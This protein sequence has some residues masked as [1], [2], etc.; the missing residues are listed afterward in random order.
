MSKHKKVFI[1]FLTAILVMAVCGIMP[2]SKQVLADTNE[3]YGETALYKGVS[4]ASTNRVHAKKGYKVGVST[5]GKKV[6]VKIFRYGKLVHSYTEKTSGIK[7]K[8]RNF[9][10]SGD[11]S[12]RVYN[13]SSK[14]LTAGVEI[15]AY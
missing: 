5:R 4:S 12:V 2:E 9:S 3:T 13:N 11:Y 1:S 15:S 6:R 7:M 10:G 14:T 8:F